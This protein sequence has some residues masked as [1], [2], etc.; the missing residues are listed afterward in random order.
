MTADEVSNW[1]RLAQS[2]DRAAYSALIGRYWQPVHGWLSGLSGDEHWAEDLTQ[3]TFVRA[4]QALPSLDSVESFRVWLFRIARNEWLTGKRTKFPRTGIH[5]IDEPVV[6]KPGPLGDAI[7]READGAL[8]DA[9]RRLAE[10]YQVAYLLWTHEAM[11]YSAVASVL[12]I[13]EETAR[14]RVCEARRR[15]ASELKPLLEPPSP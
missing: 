10:P 8:R 9:I 6:C 4:W 15:L 7:D 1:V 2:G 14:W 11:P 12:D 5:K 3:N 13:S